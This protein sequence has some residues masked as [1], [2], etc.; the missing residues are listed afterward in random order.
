MAAIVTDIKV[1]ETQER[2]GRTV[3]TV[4]MVPRTV[5]IVRGSVFLNGERTFCTNLFF[6]LVHVLV[7]F[8]CTLFLCLLK[9]LS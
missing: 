5:R 9:G 2:R 6:I 3:F 4:A 1:E 8:I 7:D